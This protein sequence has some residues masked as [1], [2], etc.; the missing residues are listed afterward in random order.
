MF[1]WSM[2]NLWSAVYVKVD[3]TLDVERDIELWFIRVSKV[4]LIFLCALGSCDGRVHS[5]CI[6][7]SLAFPFS[8]RVGLF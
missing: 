1:H 3:Y 5:E 8:S 6:M 7:H 2:F 4:A